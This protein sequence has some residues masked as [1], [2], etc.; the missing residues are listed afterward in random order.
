MQAAIVTNLD[1]LKTL[2][3]KDIGVSPWTAITQEQ[4]DAFAEATGDRQWIHCDPTRAAKDSPYGATVAHG[5]LTLSIGPACIEA[6][7][8]LEGCRLV[9]N[10]GLNRVRFPNAVRVG[11]RLRMHLK[12]L[13]LN[14][15]EGGVQATLLQTFELEGAA[16]PACIAELLLRYYL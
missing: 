6:M 9:V 8:R 14:D 2:V 7:V 15:F 10:Y 12:L 13:E 11:A 3:G 1:Q 16:K 5:L 4:V